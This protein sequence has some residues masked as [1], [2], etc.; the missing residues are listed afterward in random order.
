MLFRSLE[1]EQ[2]HLAARGDSGEDIEIKRRERGQAEE[3]NALGQAGKLRAAQGELFAETA[4]Q[5]GGMV[6]AKSAGNLPPQRGLPR[7]FLRHATVVPGEHHLGTIDEV[8]LEELRE[9]AG[10]L[11]EFARLGL[12]AKL[13]PDR[14][15]ARATKQRGQRLH[16][17]PE[18]CVAA[19]GG[20]LG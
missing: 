17:A 14:L 11:D 15:E 12:P 5:R 20:L 9:A 19:R 4:P 7:L 1:E 8:L 18:Q 13:M 3:M 16:D 10:E 2:V 6:F